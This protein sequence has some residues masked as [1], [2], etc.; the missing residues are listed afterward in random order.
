MQSVSALSQGSSS[1]L[2]GKR[3]PQNHASSFLQ[4][5]AHAAQSAAATADKRVAVRSRCRPPLRAS[6][7]A[8][9]VAALIL[10]WPQA[11]MAA[12]FKKDETPLGKAVTDGSGGATTIG[13]GGG[14]GTIA[15]T[16][17]GLA[18]VLAVV[19]GIYW[20]LK[21]A[22]KSRNGDSTGRIQVIATTHLAP[23]R[24][25]HLLRCGDE[26]LLVG[27]GESG[28]TALRIYTADEA[29]M[30]GLDDAGVADD[31]I[32]IQPPAAS[33]AAVAPVRHPIATLRA[34]TVRS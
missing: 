13:A 34:W 6:A 21:S 29:L 15:R 16:V 30:L 20:L 2:W 25:L 17:V 12:A 1:P 10:T 26:V 32:E 28:V 7:L 4:T 22:A 5:V 33:T 14:V 19:Y 8:A 23:N 9:A 24:T 31:L 11:A 27:A 3:P 18:I